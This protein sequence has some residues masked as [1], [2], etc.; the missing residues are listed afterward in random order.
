MYW[1]KKRNDY[2]FAASSLQ[3]FAPMISFLKKITVFLVIVFFFSQ[4]S[5]SQNVAL[6]SSSDLNVLINN[7]D[8]KTKVINFWAT[9]CKPCVEE[10]PFFMEA[11]NDYKE[12]ETEFIFVSVDFMSQHEK[13]EQKTKDL[14][15]TGTLVQL[16]EKGTDWI[17][18]L[19]KDWSGA[20]PYTIL[21]NPAGMRIH[22]YDSFSSYDELKKFLDKNLPN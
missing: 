7:N 3:K 21:I 16:N 2:F 22:H 19:D 6:I 14:A 13:V 4:S 8:G 10:L 20:I 5:F 1:S 9:W 12:K 11:I 17:D 15:L 18:E